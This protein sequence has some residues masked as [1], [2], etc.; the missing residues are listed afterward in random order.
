MSA[1]ALLTWLAGNALAAA[2][3][4]L[5][6]LIVQRLAPWPAVRHAA[7]VLVLVRLVAPP[8]VP[9]ELPRPELPLAPGRSDAWTDDALTRGRTASPDPVTARALPPDA[10]PGADARRAE[11]RIA[12]AFPLAA[13]GPRT[14]EGRPSIMAL[15]VGVELAGGLALLLL[16]AV[17]IRRLRLAVRR[18][19]P[20][21]AALR[22]R[23][24][25]VAGR[26]GL[27]RLPELRVSTEPV[28][29]MLVALPRPVIVLPR[30][31][32]DRLA[33]EEL[34]AILAHELVHVRRGDFLLRPLELAVGAL[35]WWLPFL[36]WVR[37]RLRAA[38]EAACDAEVVRRLPSSR[39]AYADGLLDAVELA[40]R[41]V[42][43]ARLAT[44]ATDTRNLQER[45][46][47]ILD[48]KR[49]PTLPRFLRPLA[50]AVAVAAVSLTPMWTAA[51][52]ERPQPEAPTPPDS[53]VRPAVAVRAVEAPEPA[54]STRELTV[55]VPSP[56]PAPVARAAPAGTYRVLASA[57]P[58]APEAPPTPD[59]DENVTSLELTELTLDLHRQL[60]ALERQ[61][62][63]VQAK[64]REVELQREAAELMRMRAFGNEEE[65]DRLEQDRALARARLERERTFMREEAELQSRELDVRLALEEQRIAWEQANLEGD[66]AAENEHE[67]ALIELEGRMEELQIQRM[68]MDQKR[69]RAELEARRVELE[70]RRQELD[71]GH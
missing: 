12:E 9:L 15:I 66:R 16:A 3:L 35:Y 40:S 33:P 60:I 30:D 41:S 62:T 61:T 59:L 6:A 34:D 46:V 45:L 22:A 69:Q 55:S 23:A 24:A 39:R 7:W 10:A 20:A 25:A 44:G 8:L 38:E 37:A 43:P 70:A 1:A 57:A 27:R 36:P 14:S 65:I 47:M 54:P 67:A 11:P 68:E 17:R 29:P 48:A 32:I 13:L 53:P 71:K 52:V 49:R 63:E 19:V 51:E 28:P 18:A 2:A 56:P 58:A 42:I 26:I 4:V 5:V 50:A 64:L 31:L 21:D